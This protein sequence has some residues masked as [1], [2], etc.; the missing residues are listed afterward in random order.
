MAVGTVDEFLAVLE[1]SRLLKP[2]QNADVQ[3]LAK[4]APDAI[5][6]AK[7]LARENILT[8]WQAG[9]LLAGRST[10]FLGKYKLLELLGK[11]GMGSVFLGEHV[12]MN[13]RVALKIIPRH[14]GKDPVGL[15][16][17]LAE[18]RTIAALDHPNIVQAYSVDNESDLYYLVME[19]VEGLD[20]QRLVEAEGPLDCAS[21]VDYIRQAADG[22]AHSHNR[23]MVHC[24]IKPS[25]LIVNPNGVVKILDMGLARLAGN[26]QLNGAASEND[27]RILG[28]VDY[29][30]P[31]QALRSADFNHRADIYAL[32]CTLYFLL[33]GHAPF[34]EGALTE[35]ILKHQT[36]EPQ[37]ISVQRSDVPLSLIDICKKMMAKKPAERFQTA[38]EVSHV[39]AAWRPGEKRV[40]RVLQLK[41]AEPIDELPGPDLLGADLSELF[42]K[43]IGVSSQSS[44]IGRKSKTRSQKIWPVLE[45][46]IGTP[47]RT[48]ISLSIAGLALVLLIVAIVMLSGPSDTSTVGEEHKP[49]I[50][51][52]DL[53]QNPK[54]KPIDNGTPDQQPADGKTIEKPITPAPPDNPPPPPAGQDTTSK[55]ADSQQ[56][57]EPYKPIEPIPSAVE[58]EPE[59]TDTTPDVQINIEALKD[60]VAMVDL[61]EIPKSKT[62]TNAGEKTVSLG[63]ILL[64]PSVPLQLILFGGDQA[65]KGTDNI[66]IQNDS[67]IW[68]IYVE[69]TQIANGDTPKQTDIA[70]LKFEEGKLLFNWVPGVTSIQADSLKNCGLLALV[71]G[72]QKFIQLCKPQLAE[73]L[74]LDLDKGVA[75]LTLP[76]DAL[77]N[78]ENLRVQITERDSIFPPNSL[79]PSDIL[80]LSSDEYNQTSMIFANPKLASFKVIISSKIKDQKLDLETTAYWEL[81]AQAQKIFRA[82]EAEKQL[83]ILTRRQQTLQSK[84]DTL[85]ENSPAR[86]EAEKNLPQVKM[87]IEFL[88]ELGNIYTQINKTGKINY[89]VFI[90]YGDKYKVELFTTVMPAVESVEQ[91]DP[92]QTQSAQPSTESGP[93]KKTVKKP[94]RKPKP[95]GP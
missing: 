32:G 13:R 41:K 43:G 7:T 18:A 74:I 61:P 49:P 14:I 67:S 37:P 80:E 29:M 64:P 35:R 90:L 6:L 86:K 73:P 88:Q 75:K 33:T 52:K 47:L 69:S 46:F 94:P 54:P 39:L 95:P 28:S 31:E 59:S 11:G 66:C 68:R 87:P 26:E 77:P 44:I 27:E 16:R 34:P 21:A 9:Q 48:F 20:L 85:P 79:Q 15:E 1:R 82:A 57:K 4:E 63:T 36:K 53:S 91:S 56:N 81:P 45:P 40:Q 22:L 65:V 71:Q 92:N 3:R 60:L 78:H 70:Q 76:F 8:R 38:L 17:F 58:P 24:D 83:G 5:T 55:I 62:T 10:F 84:L 72:Q 30:A 93:N 23:K 19:Y 51:S 2:E 89:C 25:N 50:D 42:R 12:M